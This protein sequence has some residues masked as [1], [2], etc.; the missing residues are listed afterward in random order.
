MIHFAFQITL[1]KELVRAKTVDRVQ[2]QGQ[3]FLRQMSKEFLL[4]KLN[5][6]TR[7]LSC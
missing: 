6:L 7:T 5:S 1:S 3:L 4:Q 2:I